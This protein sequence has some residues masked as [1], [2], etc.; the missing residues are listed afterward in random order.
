MI[1]PA[2]PTNKTPALRQNSLF[3]KT[4][5]KSVRF[6]KA[7]KVQR[8]FTL[9]LDDNDVKRPSELGSPIIRIL[10]NQYDVG[11]PKPQEV[12][13]VPL[14][15]SQIERPQKIIRAGIEQFIELAVI[16]KQM[17]EIDKNVESKKV[18]LALCGDFTILDTFRMLE[19]EG[20]IT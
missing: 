15:F 5:N 13:I 19:V 12:I 16:L 2:K 1:L 14:D 18:I 3:S 6:A 9:I 8:V 11:I 4:T 7:V 17:I 20:V 10:T